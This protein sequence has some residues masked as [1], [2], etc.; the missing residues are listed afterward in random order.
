MS[1][2][3]MAREDAALV[4]ESTVPARTEAAPQTP[5]SFIKGGEHVTLSLSERVVLGALALGVLL[6]GVVDPRSLLHGIYGL[7]IAAFIAS[8]AI[9]LAAVLT[10]RLRHIAPPLSDHALPH[11]TLIVP[12]YREANVA[13]ELVANLD[14]LDYPRHRLQALIVLETDDH[15][16]IAAFQALDLPSFIQVLVASPGEP[17]T[18]PRAC[19]VALKW[20]RG[21]LV[22]IYD[23]EDAP[24]PMQLREAAERFAAGD[25]RLA[26]LQ[27]P[28]RVETPRA[29]SFIPEQFRL[30]YAA[31]FEVLLPAFAR[32]RIPFPLGGTSNHF[33]A[34]ALRS[35]GGWDPYN[36]TEDADIG[37]RLAAAGYQLGTI[38]RPTLET[39]P[40]CLGQWGPQRARW[41]KGHLQ[42]LV[43]HGRRVT[44]QP[45]RAIAALIMTLAAPVAASN[46]HAPAML[47]AAASVAADWSQDGRLS[48]PILHVAIYG[49]CWSISAIA[50]VIGAMRSGGAAS[51]LH[52]FGMV[53]YWLMWALASPR[54]VW[55]FF[56]APHRWDKTSHAPRSPRTAPSTGRPAP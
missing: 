12:L 33:K 36:V 10:P 32:W 4:W 40:T 14:R 24:N 23:A 11:Y 46:L 15:M 35:I 26:C 56:F 9:R 3:R 47:I 2:A 41:I 1:G 49:G 7:F 52:L 6:Y 31:H 38:D 51:W 13:R 44:C 34:A 50:G 27:A 16:T 39:A 54:A 17:R 21:E 55:Q 43:V 29:M 28:L 37:F 22:V 48:I 25:D 19:N 18:K 8:G 5:A 53:G 45:P 30:E 20:T 42:T